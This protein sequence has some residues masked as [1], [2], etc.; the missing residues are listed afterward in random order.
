MHTIYI[1]LDVISNLEMIKACIGYM[2]YVKKLILISSGVQGP[3]PC[4]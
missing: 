2:F 3:I 4:M 1:I